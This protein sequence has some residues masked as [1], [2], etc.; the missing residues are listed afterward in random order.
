LE[1]SINK[2]VVET[3]DSGVKIFDVPMDPKAEGEK[4]N[5]EATLFRITTSDT[6]DATFAFTIWDK[7]IPDIRIHSFDSGLEKHER[8]KS[9]GRMSVL[10]S[11]DE[12]WLVELTA[13]KH[14]PEKGRPTLRAPKFQELDELASQDFS[15]LM[16]DLGALRLGTR[17]EIDQEDSNRKNYPAMVVPV[18]EIE[19]ILA[20][21]TVTRV[22]ALV[23]D[24]G[25]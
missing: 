21:F 7:F 3:L 4:V 22:L 8:V 13:L 5:G 6:L 20:A 15:Q 17:L 12:N 14:S 18:G 25:L 16:L 2:A 23:K 19:P 1:L 24:F 9:A 11:R 10:A